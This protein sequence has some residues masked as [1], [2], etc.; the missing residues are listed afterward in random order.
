M[1]VPR[2]FVSSTCYD[3]KYIRENIKY[4]INNMG[5]E[6]IL[7]ENGDVFYDPDQHT[8]DA[9]LT[10]VQNCQMFVLIIGGRY[11]GNYR[12]EDK[13]ITNKEYEEAVKDRIPVFALVERNVWSEHFVY[14]KI[15]KMVMPIQ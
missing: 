3:L 14:Q 6:S 8:H 13:S 4:F 5:F 11:G 7:S 1:A 9:C 10:E 12:K 15:K 2:V